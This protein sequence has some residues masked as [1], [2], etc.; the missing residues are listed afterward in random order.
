[1]PVLKMAFEQGRRFKFEMQLVLVELNCD[2]A[3]HH[4][5]VRAD[6]RIQRQRWR[7]ILNPSGDEFSFSSRFSA[8]SAARRSRKKSSNGV[9]CR[10]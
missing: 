5:R 7:G 4:I 1:M 8:G 2:V 10:W 3:V 9:A 6:I